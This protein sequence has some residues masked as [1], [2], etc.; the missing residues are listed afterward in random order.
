MF[1]KI[2]RKLFFKM[3]RLRVIKY[4]LLS[5]CRVVIGSARYRQPTLLLGKGRIEF[6]CDVELGFFPSP[7]FFNGYQHIESRTNDSIIKVGERVMINNNSFICSE[8]AGISIGDDCLVGCNVQIFDSDFH[9]LSPIERKTG[10]PRVAAVNIQNNV[11]IGSNV[12]ICKGV[13]IGENSVIGAGSIVTSS[14]PSDSIAAGNPAVV[15][16]NL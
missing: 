4:K 6:G 15:V 9:S 14:I 12:I 1:K 5:N 7:Y 13:N 11:F 16:K 8:G 3:H 2:V 10:S